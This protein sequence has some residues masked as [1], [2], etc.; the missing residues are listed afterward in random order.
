M[1]TDLLPIHNGRI[2][3]YILL[4]VVISMVSLEMTTDNKMYDKI[5]LKVLLYLT[6]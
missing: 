4:S 6:N 2:L 1:S 3:S 5:L